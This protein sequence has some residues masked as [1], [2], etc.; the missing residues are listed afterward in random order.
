MTKVDGPESSSVFR[1][2]HDNGAWLG[3]F[4]YDALVYGTS[5]PDTMLVFIP[6]KGAGFV[7]AGSPESDIHWLD[8]EGSSIHRA[9]TGLV[10]NSGV[11]LTLIRPKQGVVW[12]SARLC[13]DDLDYQ[14]ADG[15]WI[16]CSC[17]CMGWYKTYEVS[18]IDGSSIELLSTELIV[19]GTVTEASPSRMSNAPLGGANT[20]AFVQAIG[21]MLKA[22][23]DALRF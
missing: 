3:D 4:G 13:L 17:V 23:I 9:G 5:D 2:S 18:V 15:D 22:A 14:F 7:D 8:A 20:P 1:I 10:V 19:D 21:D 16:T 6:W 11:D 12:R